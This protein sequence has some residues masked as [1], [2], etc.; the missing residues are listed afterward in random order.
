LGVATLLSTVWL[1]QTYLAL[2]VCF[3]LM[4]VF[5]FGAVTVFATLIAES[6]PTRIRATGATVVASTG[7][8]LGFIVFPV[9]TST[10]AEDWMGWNLMFSTLIAIPYLMAAGLFLLLPRIKSGL[11]VEEVV[12]EITQ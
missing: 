3:A 5:L 8:D 11:E 4:G 6:F 2:A 12:K 7:L 9:L 1:A 10:A